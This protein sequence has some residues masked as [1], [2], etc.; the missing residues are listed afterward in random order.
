MTTTQPPS[1]IKEERPPLRTIL[2]DRAVLGFFTAR[3][4]ALLGNSM[5]PIALAFATLAIP[6][7]SATDLGIVLLSRALVQI[8]F[9]LIGGV[10][11]DRWERRRVMVLSDTAAGCTQAGIAALVITGSAGTLSL[12]LLS[13]LS[14]AAAAMFDPAAR[15]LMP[16]LVEK[17][18]LQAANALLR[19]SMRTAAIAGTALAGVF[20]AG[21][22][23]GQ[24]LLVNAATFLASALLVS[25]I[26]RGRTDHVTDTPTS[27]G[28]TFLHLLRTGWRE[29]V[30]R[31]W[32]WPTVL[33]LGLVNL[34]LAGPFFVL[35]PIVAQDALGGARAW[36]TISTAQALGFVAGSVL[37]LRL[38]PRFPLRVTA[39][40]TVGFPLPLFF[41]AFEQ[42]L[43]TVAAASFAAGMC[44]DVYDV[45][46]ETTLQRH[47]P[48][49]ALARVMSYETFGS[50]AMVPVG[51]A[52]VGPVA[53]LAGTGPTLLGAACVIVATGPL[54]LFVSAVR[55]FEHEPD[56]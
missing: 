5:A 46:L 17:D 27:G 24:T 16:S 20:V 35:G 54:L 6:G 22:G 40:L 42:P 25:R 12:A 49:E 26:P 19:S 29:F 37:V 56:A 9:L 53:A 18:R 41:M 23:P 11:A 32:V 45:L 13:M 51:L 30:S 33:Q 55:R 2:R 8:A 43:V 14:G 34:L 50:F 28:P 48:G 31:R 21:I 39:L 3:T 38:R 47:I 10:V 7:G 36:A 52:V 44:I 15:S 4:V 1:G